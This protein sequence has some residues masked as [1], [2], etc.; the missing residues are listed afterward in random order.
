MSGY[1][2]YSSDDWVLGTWCDTDR[3][4]DENNCD[5]IWSHPIVSTPD[6]TNIN[7]VLELWPILVGLEC[8]ANLLKDTT[9]CVRVDNI[10]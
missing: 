4:L 2:V 8:W 9:L 3:T 10:K 7:N 1:G 6:I 5:H